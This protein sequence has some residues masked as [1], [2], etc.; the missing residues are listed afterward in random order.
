MKIPA[1]CRG[2]LDLKTGRFWFGE[3]AGDGMFDTRT[4]TFREFPPRNP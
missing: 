3:F 2:T 1:P 4:E